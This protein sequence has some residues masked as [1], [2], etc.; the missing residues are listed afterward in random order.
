MH[1]V[2]HHATKF[3]PLSTKPGTKFPLCE[4]DSLR[5]GFYL[6]QVINY[7]NFSDPPMLYSSY[8]KQS[9]LLR[10]NMKHSRFTFKF[11]SAG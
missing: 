10:L 7:M 9:I 6:N 8:L 11:V 3:Q 5:N 2:F 4:S 1:D